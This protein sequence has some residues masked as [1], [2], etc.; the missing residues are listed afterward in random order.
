MLLWKYTVCKIPT[1]QCFFFFYL[2]RPV[3]MMMKEIH[4]LPFGFCSCLITDMCCH[5]IWAAR[6]H[7]R[8][9]Q[10]MCHPILY[11]PY[12]TWMFSRIHQPDDAQF[13]CSGGYFESTRR[14][15]R[16]KKKKRVK[17]MTCEKGLMKRLQLL[18]ELKLK[19][20]RQVSFDRVL[21]NLHSHNLFSPPHNRFAWIAGCI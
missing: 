11:K 4:S 18:E 9:H 1:L 2:T 8:R 5:Q 10:Q 12:K 3:T 17:S 6:A 15:R 16:R 13:L 14:K 19:C 20:Y 21:H 7:E